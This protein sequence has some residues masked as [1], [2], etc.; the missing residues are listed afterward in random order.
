MKPGACGNGGRHG[1][2]DGRTG[3]SLAGPA[4]A[5]PHVKGGSAVGLTANH[6]PRPGLVH[7]D[8][9]SS[10]PEGAWLRS[11]RPGSASAVREE[12]PPD[13]TA[14]RLGSAAWS[15]AFAP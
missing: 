12:A 11:R 3:A 14:V 5:H 9:P 13:P 10:A 4:P 8:A 1:W 6:Q 15:W 7:P 2:A